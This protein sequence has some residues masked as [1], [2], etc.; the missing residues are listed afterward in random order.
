MVDSSTAA[1]H[2]AVPVA[3][4]ASIGSRVGGGSSGGPEE[5]AAQALSPF[6]RLS[7]EVVLAMFEFVLDLETPAASKQQLSTDAQSPPNISRS[8][9][10][11]VFPFDLI[12]DAAFARELRRTVAHLTN[13]GVTRMA[14]PYA[15][16][17]SFKHSPAVQHLE[18]NFAGESLGA[19]DAL[20]PF[21][22]LLAS[23]FPSLMSL[24]L[25]HVHFEAVRDIT[26]FEVDPASVAA[27]APPDSL[28]YQL[29]HLALL[30]FLSCLRKSKVLVF[31]WNR[32]VLSD[33]WVRK[34]VH[35]DFQVD[36]YRPF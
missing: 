9:L 27:D 14:A 24:E 20:Y 5:T 30:P 1:L 32:G 34:T 2:G 12:G 18:I 6:D 29:H 33:R 3:I 31:E 35:E 19:K 8:T 23:S 28:K 25:R 10:T 16:L 15:T 36:R 7:D 13:G 22:N 21:A 11:R 26:S 4:A 17:R